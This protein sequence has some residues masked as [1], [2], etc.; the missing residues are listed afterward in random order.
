MESE[1]LKASTAKGVGLRVP[2]RVALRAPLR[3]FGF[4]AYRG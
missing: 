4:G 1:I 2:L 3:A